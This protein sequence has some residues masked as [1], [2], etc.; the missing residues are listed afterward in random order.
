[1]SYISRNIDLS[2][3][4]EQ[5]GGLQCA[6]MPRRALVWSRS[7]LEDLEFAPEPATTIADVDLCR[8]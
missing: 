8:R 1:M 7:D 3:G 5:A 2:V 6:L 4:K